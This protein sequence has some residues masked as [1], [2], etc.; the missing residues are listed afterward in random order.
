MARPSARWGRVLVGASVAVVGAEVWHVRP[1][2]AGD[3]QNSGSDD[4]R[5]STGMWCDG[6]AATTIL[7]DTTSVPIYVSDSNDWP[8]GGP[9]NEQGHI[10][11][12]IWIYTHNE[13]SDVYMETGINNGL[14]GSG[15][16]EGYWLWWSDTNGKTHY[17][18]FI[19]REPMNNG[20]Q[21]YELW[22]SSS[23]GDW[24]AYSTLTGYTYAKS[25]IQVG[26]YAWEWTI[27]ME[28]YDGDSDYCQPGSNPCSPALIDPDEHTGGT[29][30]NHLQVAPVG[31]PTQQFHYPTGLDPVYG[32]YIDQP[33][34]TGTG[35]YANGYCMNGTSYGN[36]E[37]SDN[38]PG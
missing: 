38:I 9:A 28:E 24:Y 17:N 18:H 36:G 29:F 3:C 16:I 2:V 32:A 37:W 1:A 14:N 31:V 30:D 33:C 15:G 23:D 12:E 8:G 6:T 20:Y 22:Y 10:N 4:H 21:G 34:G 27:G 25:I 35:R 7:F 13:A 26:V 11:N 19:A 5:Y